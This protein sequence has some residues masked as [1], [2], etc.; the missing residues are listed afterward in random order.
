MIGIT[1]SDACLAARNASGRNL[2][3]VSSLPENLPED[4][5]EHFISAGIA[6]LNGL[7]DACAAIR[8]AANLS[9]TNDPLPIL[10]CPKPGPA[11]TLSEAEAKA[12]LTR[13]GISIPQSVRCG[14]GDRAAMSAA[15]IGFPVVLKGEGFEHKTEN[16]AVALNLHSSDAVKSAAERM[17]ASEYLVERQVTGAVAELLIGIVRDDAHGLVLTI[18]AGGTLTELLND[19]QIPACS[20][21]C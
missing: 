12:E 16:G 19:R 17:K 4:V 13:F 2:A 10:L 15:E 9:G 11:T 5:A 14:N 20:G 7:E 18:G 1:P 21:F 6:P 8:C 3:V